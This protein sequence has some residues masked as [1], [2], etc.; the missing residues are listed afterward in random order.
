MLWGPL[1]VTR[2]CSR[3][4]QRASLHVRHDGVTVTIAFTA[5]CMPPLELSTPCSLHA[6]ARWVALGL[7]SSGA[8][9]SGAAALVVG[10]WPV[11]LWTV[12]EVAGLVVAFHLIAAR[13][14][15]RE[16]ISVLDNELV[17]KLQSRQ[18]HKEHRFNRHWAVLHVLEKGVCRDLAIRYAGRRYPLGRF[19]SDERREWLVHQLAGHVRVVREKAP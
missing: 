19:V 6:N 11:L 18:G 16:I 13:V 9:L 17:V 14:T 7:L 5:T 15:E 4:P 3:L 1:F 2:G 12:V 10:A 8:L